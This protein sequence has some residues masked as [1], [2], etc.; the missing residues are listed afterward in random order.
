MKQNHLLLHHHP[1]M[2]LEMEVKSRLIIQEDFLVLVLGLGCP[3]QRWLFS[4]PDLRNI[5]GKP[6]LPN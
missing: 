4:E 2:S 6:V 5:P 1:A 3:G